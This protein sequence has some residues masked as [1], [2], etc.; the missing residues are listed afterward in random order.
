MLVYQRVVGQRVQTNPAQICTAFFEVLIGQKWVPGKTVDAVYCEA[1][2][3]KS[4]EQRNSM[5][6]KL[7]STISKTLDFLQ[8]PPDHFISDL[9]KWHIF[10]IKHP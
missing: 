7:Y 4:G 5:Y 6:L 2:I 10:P 8:S 9:F 3:W 1:T